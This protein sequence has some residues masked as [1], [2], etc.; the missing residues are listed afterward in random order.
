MISAELDV[1]VAEGALD[2]VDAEEAV[3]AEGA[4]E[5]VEAVEAEEAED[6]VVG[7]V[8]GAAV[9]DS[10]ALFVS[11]TFYGKNIW[12]DRTSKQMSGERMDW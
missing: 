5:A 4:E 12:W 2:G 8:A 1:V 10:A 9:V 7:V 3:D 6:A 11:R